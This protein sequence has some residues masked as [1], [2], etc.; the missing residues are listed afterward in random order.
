MIGSNRLALVIAYLLWLIFPIWWRWRSDACREH[1]FADGVDRGHAGLEVSGAEA[2][3]D[4]QGRPAA[5]VLLIPHFDFGAFG[6]EEFG[7]LRQAFVGGAV[8]GGLVLLVHDI[9]V[10][11]EGEEVFAGG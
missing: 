10:R 1:D 2:L 11:A 6:G 4:E 3:G 7:D 8:H 5:V 9:H